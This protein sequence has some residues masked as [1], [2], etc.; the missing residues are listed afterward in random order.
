MNFPNE[1]SSCW[2]FIRSLHYINL[3]DHQELVIQPVGESR[4][5]SR[6]VL[7][8]KKYK[9]NHAQHWKHDNGQIQNRLT[10]LCIDY[11]HGNY[12]R[13]GDIHIC[14]WHKKV[15]KESHNQKWIY[16]TN[17]LIASN[18]DINRVLHIKGAAAEPGAEVLLKKLETVHG[19][20]PTHQ[21]WALDVVVDDDEDGESH[22]SRPASSRTSTPA[23]NQ[24][25]AIAGSYLPP[26]E[27]AN[28]WAQLNDDDDNDD[29]PARGK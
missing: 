11:E 27:Y 6:L 18:D 16:R 14:Q 28:P 10:G 25:H 26:V 2:F 19:V 1:D 8:Q 4:E 15:G 17:N 7:S 22:Q 29:E 23:I 5:P 13:L 12:K 3:S 9:N 21:R 20:H 24:G